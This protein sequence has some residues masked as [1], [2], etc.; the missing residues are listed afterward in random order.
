[1][2][3]VRDWGKGMNGELVL[4]EVVMVLVCIYCCFVD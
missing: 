2:E 4:K 3:W 1:M